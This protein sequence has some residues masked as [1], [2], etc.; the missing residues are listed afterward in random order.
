MSDKLKHITEYLDY[1]NAL[2]PSPKYAVLLRGAWGSGKT[3]FIN[4]HLKKLNHIYISLNGVSSLNEIEDS[5]YQQL[6]PFLSSSAMKVTSQVLKGLLKTAIK[7]DFNGDGKDDATVTGAAANV[8]IS[9]N[10]KKIDGKLIV[11]DDLERC[12]LPIQEIMGYINNFIEHFELKVIILADE[13]KGNLNKKKYRKAKEKII[14]KS[15]T[16]TPNVQQALK[17]FIDSVSKK[18]IIEKHEFIIL[19]TFE[20]SKFQNLRHLRNGI[21]HLDKFL[22]YFEQSTLKNEE[23]SRNLIEIFFSIH[24]EINAGTMREEDISKLFS[25]RTLEE[26]STIKKISQ[27]HGCFEIYN[28]TLNHEI[29]E[30]FFIFGYIKNDD[31]KT[32]IKESKYFK[33]PDVKDWENFRTNWELTDESY[34]ALEQKMLLRLKK[35]EVKSLE[36]LIILA[37]SFFFYIENKICQKTPKDIVQL[38][39]S[40]IETLESDNLFREQISMRTNEILKGRFG[41]KST[42]D[43]LKTRII[44]IVLSKIEKGQKIQLES[45]LQ[46]LQGKIES[47]FEEFSE[48]IT[49]S[50]YTSTEEKSYYDIPVFKFFD[51]DKLA[52]SILGLNASKINNFGRL[53][54]NRYSLLYGTIHE[55]KEALEAL[56]K[57]IQ[58][59]I[60]EN[61]NSLNSYNFREYLLKDLDTTVVELNKVITAEYTK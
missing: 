8:E 36:E 30:S 42:C 4:N 14:G 34:T 23:F 50:N 46:L 51:Q 3:Y 31:L 39:L 59:Y 37:D 56:S 16:I 25:R 27:K 19:S 24:L 41:F 61:P 26:E 40:N 22:G 35:N 17:S 9:K 38:T 48:Q 53:I 6:H 7:V 54:K 44:P 43:N 21:S 2:E 52:K 55:D 10:I 58:K 29:F 33:S 18:T 32:A 13:T 15:F 49:F 12:R 60:L 11:F 28:Q 57:S 1:Y 20:R 5:I 47:N 45:E